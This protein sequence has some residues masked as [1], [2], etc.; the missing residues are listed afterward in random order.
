MKSRHHFILLLAAWLGIQP[1]GCSLVGFVHG[2]RIDA[3]TPEKDVFAPSTVDRIERGRTI[4]VL[5]TDSTTVSGECAGSSFQPDEKYAATYTEQMATSPIG[6]LLPAMGD[7]LLCVTRS[8]RARYEATG[9][10][11][12]FSEEALRLQSEKYSGGEAN[13]PLKYIDTVYFARGL[14]ISGES[15]RGYVA[16][17]KIPLIRTRLLVSREK[18][19]IYVPTDS[20]LE[21][22]S[23]NSHH[24][25]WVELGIGAAFDVL[26]IYIASHYE[27]GPLHLA[28]R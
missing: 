18:D 14:M 13:L 21:V 28:L 5:R 7:S 8:V 11:I 19:T 25:K 23:P 12:G 10:L 16:G 17:G 26:V 22:W 27:L 15:L 3:T 9:Q 4:I 24:R 6:N 2:S 1:T 20:V